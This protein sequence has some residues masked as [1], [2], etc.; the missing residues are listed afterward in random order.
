L[1]G[2][3]S[4]LFSYEIPENRT[5]AEKLSMNKLHHVQNQLANLDVGKIFKK[6]AMENGLRVPACVDKEKTNRVR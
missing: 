3:S 5:D 2:A 6:Y 1:L 4:A